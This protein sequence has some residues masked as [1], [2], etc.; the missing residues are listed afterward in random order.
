MSKNKQKRSSYAKIPEKDGEN[1]MGM[2]EI[3]AILIVIFLTTALSGLLFT[4]NYQDDLARN[5]NIEIQ[6]EAKAEKFE[7]EYFKNYDY[8][9]LSL[10]RIPDSGIHKEES[11]IGEFF[12]I[13]GNK[14]SVAYFNA[15]RIC[16]TDADNKNMHCQPN[17]NEIL[18]QLSYDK[19]RDALYKLL[20]SIGDDAYV[21]L[22]YN[23]VTFDH[24]TFPSLIANLYM[25][26]VGGKP[27]IKK[28]PKVINMT[29]GVNDR[30]FQAKNIMDKV[31][32]QYGEKVK[33]EHKGYIKTDSVSP[34][35]PFAINGDAINVEKSK[36]L[37]NKSTDS[38]DTT[39]SVEFNYPY[40]VI[41]DDTPIGWGTSNAQMIN[42]G[43]LA[44]GYAA[45]IQGEDCK[46]L[47]EKYKEGV[48]P[49]NPV[50][51][52]KFY[53][54]CKDPKEYS[55]RK[56]CIEKDKNCEKYPSVRKN[57]KLENFCL[58]TEPCYVKYT[59]EDRQLKKIETMSGDYMLS[60][61][62]NLGVNTYE[63][64]FYP[65]YQDT[66]FPEEQKG[67]IFSANNQGLGANGAKFYFII[68]L[69][70]VPAPG[71]HY[72]DSLKN[73]NNY[74]TNKYVIQIR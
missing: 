53:Y 49:D 67:M 44:D 71:K 9:N 22:R 35:N 8:L 28:E 73:E 47:N 33:R 15:R 59:I 74:I 63:N 19:G 70:Y 68:G 16:Y 21:N 18:D 30:I 14:K 52:S 39:G 5:K 2:I 3:L 25:A 57:L 24:N 56:N 31:Y 48:H 43:I 12:D 69:K 26:Y 42:F 4:V 62:F 34:Y 1:I 6:I 36:I 51:S 66:L 55:Y 72:T 45:I 20:A 50:F 23:E 29:N 61:D 64:P 10:E 38:S 58:S 60:K 65:N 54:A 41:G 40:N 37:I 46:I 32:A 7:T 13:L 27:D 11:T 17:M